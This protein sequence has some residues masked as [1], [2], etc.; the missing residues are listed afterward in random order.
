MPMDKGPVSFQS[1]P[2]AITNLTTRQGPRFVMMY[3]SN[4]SA[5]AAGDCVSIDYT[6]TAV[7]KGE[8]VKKC[9]TAE[10]GTCIGAAHTA[11]ADGA[12]GLIQVAGYDADV[13]AESD[14]STVG[15]LAVQSLSTAARVQKL[16]DLDGNAYASAKLLVLGRVTVVV[17][18]N[19]VGLTW[20]GSVGY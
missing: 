4:G 1:D 5:L 11:I 8:A 2:A 3:N 19:V 9:A 18:S 12:W 13:K 14:L 7:A 16:A 6:E 15:D 10:P 17:S 20:F